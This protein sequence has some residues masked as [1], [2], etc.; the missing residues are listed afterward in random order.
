MEFQVG[1]S[2]MVEFWLLLL[3][4]AVAVGAL[5]LLRRFIRDYLISSLS[6][7]C[8]RQILGSLTLSLPRL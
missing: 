1:W 6:D 5:K 8:L 4:Y 7:L 2:S 3:G